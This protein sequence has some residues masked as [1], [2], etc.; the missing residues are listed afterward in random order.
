MSIVWV[1]ILTDNDASWNR[2]G[3]KHILELFS[4]FG[5]VISSRV[6]Q[7]KRA[8]PKTKRSVD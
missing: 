8:G 3:E 7:R 1:E 5:K 4:I 6:A 2:S